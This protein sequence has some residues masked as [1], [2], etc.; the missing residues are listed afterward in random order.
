[1]IHV[2]YGNPNGPDQSCSSPNQSGDNL[3][4]T[5]PYTANRF[6]IGNT[7]VYTD[8]TAALAATG[9]G[10]ATVTGAQLT[11][12]SGWKA[13]Q[14]ATISNVTVND[15]TWVPKTTVTTTS[16]VTGD[17]AKTCTLPAAEL[18]WAKNDATPD[19]AIN[20]AESIQP[21]DT[22]QFYRQVDCK[23]I[24]NLDVTSLNGTGTYTVW[25]RING[26]NLQVPATFDLK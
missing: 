22:G 17:F 2:Y 20:E 11:L 19:G 9:G 15:N 23:Y 16:T 5:S 8:Y 18:R 14:R 6:E 3:I 24:Y 12:D 13:D 1:V 10:T 26:M 7:G 4:T 25:V 21:K